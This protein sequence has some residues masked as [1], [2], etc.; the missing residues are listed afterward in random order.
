MKHHRS[1]MLATGI[2]GAILVSVLCVPNL[3]AQAQESGPVFYEEYTGSINSF[4]QTTILDLSGGYNFNRHFGIDGGLPIHFVDRQEGS[5]FGFPRAPQGWSNGAGDLYMD[6]L[7]NE[8]NSIVNYSSQA[9][10]FAP[11]GNI[12]QGFST[13]RLLVDWNNHIYRN[14]GPLTPFADLSFG[15]TLDDRH[16]FVRPFDTLGKVFQTEAGSSLRV[17]PRTYVG[18]SWYHVF[19][20]GSQKIFS[21]LVTRSEGFVRI[22]ITNSRYFASNYET[23]GPSSILDDNG[24]S[25]WVGVNTIHNLDFELNYGRSLRYSLDSLSFRVG[26]NAGSFVKGLV[27]RI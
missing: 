7:F 5:T 23:V 1:L 15:N 27:P 19:P 17:A 25:G 10:T 3:L 9:R 20:D 24:F 21:Q 22:P 13:G 6:L 8:P 14:V 11:I 18:G 26:F 16:Y 2:L 4:G 12:D